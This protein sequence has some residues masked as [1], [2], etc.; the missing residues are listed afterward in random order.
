VY[1]LEGRKELD[2]IARIL[3]MK[4]PTI[5]AMGAGK[6]EERERERGARCCVQLIGPTI[7]GLAQQQ[8]QQIF[9]SSLKH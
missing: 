2:F 9:I 1:K 5:S 3:Q 6:P 4:Q 7:S 8:Q